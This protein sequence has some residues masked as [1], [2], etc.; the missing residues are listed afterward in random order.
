MSGHFASWLR[1]IANNRITGAKV[2]SS[3]TKPSAN[4]TANAWLR[5]DS[6]QGAFLRRKKAHMGV[7]KSITAMANK[8]ASLCSATR[9]AVQLGYALIPIA[10]LGE[11]RQVPNPSL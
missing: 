9:R 7:T 8:L 2:L 6:S 10:D 1:L 3:R 4:R 11:V 5:S